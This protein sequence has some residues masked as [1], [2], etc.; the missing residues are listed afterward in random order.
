MPNQLCLDDQ[1]VIVVVTV[2]VV[3]AGRAR[4]KLLGQYDH[5]CNTGIV[6]ALRICGAI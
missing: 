2:V 1:Q 3:V 4:G 6:R 5:G